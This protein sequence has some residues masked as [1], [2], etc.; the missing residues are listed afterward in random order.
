M[1]FLGGKWQKK[2]GARVKTF[3]SVVSAF[4]HPGV[5]VLVEKVRMMVAGCELSGFFPFDK[6]RVRMTAE[7]KSRSRSPIRL[8]SGQALRG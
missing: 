6:L 4:C 1:R 3:D 2:N 8:R 7:A 5:E